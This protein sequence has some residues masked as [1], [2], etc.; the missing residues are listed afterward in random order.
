VATREND[1]DLMAHY[2]GELAGAADAAIADAIADDPPSRAKLEAL[3]QISEVVRTAVELE[4][5]AVA[6]RR[7]DCFEAMWANIERQISANGVRS[8][9]GAVEPT[10]R[11]EVDSAEPAGIFG[12]IAAW[13]ERYRSQIASG[14]LA[15]AA[16]AVL[17]WFVRPPE[18]SIEYVPVERSTQ[19]RETAEVVP[20]ALEPTAPEIESLEVYDGN[21]VV[22]TVAGDEEEAD[23]VVIWLSSEEDSVEGPI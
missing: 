11:P 5:D 13:F 20:V 7:A 12:A 4:V 6:E 18:T 3:G 16:A 21:G 9:A 10:R 19:T 15:A 14:A 17:V 8:K 2:D 1:L 23:S 22:L